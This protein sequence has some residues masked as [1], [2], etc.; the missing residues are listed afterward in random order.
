MREKLLSVD[1]AAELLATTEPVHSHPFTVGDHVRFRVNPGWQH[2]LEAKQG[3]DLVDAFILLGGGA[4]VTEYPLTRDA[5][6][7]ATSLIRLT[8]FYASSCPAEL[9][10]PTL[11]YWYRDGLLA[12][13]RQRARDY[14]VLVVGGVG[15]AVSRASMMP[16]SNLALLEKVAA[17]MRNAF[18]SELLVDYK[19]THGLRRTHLRLIAPDHVRTITATGV[20]DDIWSLGVQI[21]NSLIGQ[22]PTSVEGYLFRWWCT[23]GAIDTRN[24]SGIVRRQ[25]RSGEEVYAW[26]A[27]AV[28]EVLGGLEGSLDAVQAMVAM[29]IEGEAGEVLRDVFEFYRV[30]LVERAKVI[31]LLERQDSELTMYSVMAAITQVANERGLDAGHVES[32]LRL[33]GDLPHAA[34]SRCSACRRLTHQH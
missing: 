20:P 17:G 11:N 10:E 13:P 8:T 28:D 16:F 24:S 30:P 7:Q 2:G 19:L 27:E 14:Q 1:Q 26:A 23:N 25:G 18:G 5:L 15:A 31:E 9:L 6:L 32:L 29:T 3:T 33:G 34:S 4:Q 22:V 12:G 21:N